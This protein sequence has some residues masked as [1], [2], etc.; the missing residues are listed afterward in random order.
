[1]TR[2]Y[3]LLT[4]ATVSAVWTRWQRGETAI[5]VEHE[6]RRRSA[7]V[8]LDTEVDEQPVVPQ[9]VVVVQILVAQG[10][11][12]DGLAHETRH[13]VRD[14]CRIAIVPKAR[15]KLYEGR[16]RQTPYTTRG[17]RFSTTLVRNPG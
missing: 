4:P 7:R 12:V 10:E 1:M 6:L 15:G 5:E 17:S 16:S 8:R 13:R 11:P 3:N 2:P 9:C 14:A